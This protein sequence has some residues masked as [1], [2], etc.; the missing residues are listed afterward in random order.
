MYNIYI[1][2]KEEF[3]G[4]FRQFCIQ[5]EVE[6]KWGF[7]SIVQATLNLFKT[8]FQNEDNKY[9]VLLSDK[10]IPLYNPHNL[11]ERITQINNNMLLYMKEN[12]IP[13]YKSL[14]KKEFFDQD[15]FK[16][17][18]QWM[19]LKRDTVKFLIENDYTYIF[20]DKM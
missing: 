3:T 1:H 16:R 7:I 6:T 19:L 5:D 4:Q 9:F 11:Y 20:G 13:R 17:Q 8:A 15:T 18:S 10:C 2:K 14:A 12:H